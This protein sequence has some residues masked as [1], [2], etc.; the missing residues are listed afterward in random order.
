MRL[1]FGTCFSSVLPET[2]VVLFVCGIV[3]WGW[4]ILVNL[5]AKPDVTDLI[6]VVKSCEV[7]G[8][9]ADADENKISNSNAPSKTFC[10][11]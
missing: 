7:T 5:V 8:V 11:R 2:L 4:K 3:A 1:V 6:C 9:G 10:T